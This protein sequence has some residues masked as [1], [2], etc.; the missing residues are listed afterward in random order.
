MKRTHFQ[1]EL[2]QEGRVTV[3]DF[4]WEGAHQA[5]QICGHYVSIHKWPGKQRKD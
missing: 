2:K 1:S 4:R 5:A 3:I